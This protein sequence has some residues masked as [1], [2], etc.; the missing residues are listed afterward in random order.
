[1]RIRYEAKGRDF[2]ILEEV[3]CVDAVFHAGTLSIDFQFATRNK[4]TLMKHNLNSAEEYERAV[5]TFRSIQTSLALNGYANLVVGEQTA[6]IDNE[7]DV[8]LERGRI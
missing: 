8:D 3:T 7:W 4:L 5:Q 2:P 1:M 6:L